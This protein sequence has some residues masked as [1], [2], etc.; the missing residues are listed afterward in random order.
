MNSKFQQTYWFPKK[1]LCISPSHVRYPQSHY[2]FRYAILKRGKKNIVVS[3]FTKSNYVFNVHISF[4]QRISKSQ[5]SQQ[6]SVPDL[7]VLTVAFLALKKTG[8]SKITFFS[9]KILKNFN[10]I[11]CNFSVRTLKYF[12]KHRKTTLKSCL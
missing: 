1:I 10:F 8:F 11:L 2:F 9:K 7:N 3:C 12:Q 4:C 5:Y 6:Q